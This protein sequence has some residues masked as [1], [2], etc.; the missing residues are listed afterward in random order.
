MENNNSKSGNTTKV[1]LGV[2]LA[3]SLGG[4]V[5]QMQNTKTEVQYVQAKADSLVIE[6]T[7]I[8]NELKATYDE[9]D[10]YKGQNAQLD[11]LL[12]EANSRVDDQKLR[13]NQLIKTSKNSQELNSKLQAELASL[14]E[15]RDQYLDKIDSLMLANQ[16]LTVDKEN[17]T[18]KVDELTKDLASTVDKASIVGVEYVKLATFKKRGNDKYSVT[19]LAK[20]TN[21]FESSFTIMDNKIAKAGEKVVYLQITEPGGKVLGNRS[22]G[23]NKFT[24]KGSNE[25]QLFTTSTKINYNN[26]KQEVTMK[27]E[28]EERNFVAGAY[29][30]NIYLDNMLVSSTNI[31]LK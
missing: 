7:D 5:Y 15:M 29:K 3:A 25:E 22:E 14:R 4:N 28:E 27:Y 31:F 18:G 9:L 24:V 23:S 12:A 8:E 17:L 16:Q 10:K 19:S 13:I 21:K 6:K 30:V 2:L 11:S 1:V 26:D 20:R